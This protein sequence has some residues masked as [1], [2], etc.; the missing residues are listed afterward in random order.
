MPP[1]RSARGTPAAALAA[2]AGGGSALALGPLPHA[3]ILKVFALLPVD[4]RL[5]CSEVCRGWRAAL[6]ERS[7]WVRLDLSKKTGGLAR[8]ATNA[9]LRAAAARAGDALEALDVSGCFIKFDELVMAVLAAEALQ[10]LRMAR[11]A[12]VISREVIE[13]LLST[14]PQLRTLTADVECGFTDAQELLR[15]APPFAPLRVS[16]LQVRADDGLLGGQQR[17][18]TRAGCGSV[19]ARATGALCARRHAAG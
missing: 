8:H 16:L 11:C 13:L 4:A 12:G 3:L 9:L 1:R 14:S 2:G 15:G 5:R 18:C 10:E 6:T 19:N 17:G 7:L